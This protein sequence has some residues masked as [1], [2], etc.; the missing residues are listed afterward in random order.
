MR[1]K[2]HSLI[3]IRIIIV[4]IVIV[5]VVVVTRAVILKTHLAFLGFDLKSVDTVG[6]SE[7][8]W[9]IWVVE[10]QALELLAWG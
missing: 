4:V 6:I 5:I 7:P 8:D 1:T 9:Q 10:V 3:T 2:R